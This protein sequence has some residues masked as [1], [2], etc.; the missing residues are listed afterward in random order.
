MALILIVAALAAC[1]WLSASITSRTRAVLPDGTELHYSV[2]TGAVI[3]FIFGIFGPLIV[4]MW[5]STHMPDGTPK[6]HLASTAIRR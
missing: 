3:G 1:A 6:A 4:A 5:V 2:A